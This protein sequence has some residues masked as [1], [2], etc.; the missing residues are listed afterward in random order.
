MLR[1]VALQ[2]VRHLK[3]RGLLRLQHLAKPP[4]HLERGVP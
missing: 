3:A 4:A 1:C 2:S